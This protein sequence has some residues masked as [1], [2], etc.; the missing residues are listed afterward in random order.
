MEGFRVIFAQQSERDLKS[1]SRYISRHAGPN[2]AIRFGNQLIDRALTLSKLPERG[3]VVPELGDEPTVNVT[4][5]DLG[6]LAA[7]TAA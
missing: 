7:A 4:L 2:T 3:R 6:E 5:A 1:I